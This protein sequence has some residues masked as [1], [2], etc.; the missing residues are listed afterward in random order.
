MEIKLSSISRVIQTTTTV[1][2]EKKNE[3][4]TYRKGDPE[5]DAFEA[6]MVQKA[7]PEIKLPKNFL[8]PETVG[9]R[10]DGPQLSRQ[11][12]FALEQYHQG[13]VDAKAVEGTMS[14]VI[15]EVRSTYIDLGFDPSE[16][17]PQLIEDVYDAARL[18]NVHGAYEASWHDSLPYAT[19][20]NGHGGN[21][22]DWI[23]YDA[24]FY[25]SSESMKTTLQEIAQNIGE[26]YG[27]PTSN[28]DLATT[29]SDGDLR[30]AIYSSYN[31]IVCDKARNDAHVGSMID[32]A[33]APPEGF[34]FFYKGNANG[35]NLVVPTLDAPRDEMEAA[36][37]GVLQAWFGDWSFMGRVP[38]RQNPDK[39]PTSVNMFD[40]INNVDPGGVPSEITNF[41][42]NFDF[43]SQYMSGYYTKEHPRNY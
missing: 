30:K 6:K 7:N 37:D 39:Y 35:T 18:G 22:R 40:V 31:T 21:S 4:V 33:L 10:Y 9:G 23:Y 32:E 26:K 2:G 34:R 24:D 1:S 17:M 12:R 16:F 25:Y 36:F 28:L 20:Q 15:A 13:E 29:Y 11:I 42:Q 8:G 38:V 14:R 43:F 3:S 19:A 41:L 27:V 5:F